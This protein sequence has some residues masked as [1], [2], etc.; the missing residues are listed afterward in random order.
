MFGEVLKLDILETFD[1]TQLT[2]HAQ[3][4]VDFEYYINK[5][6]HLNEKYFNIYLISYYSNCFRLFNAGKNAS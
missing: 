2:C 6:F 1:N 5:M 4:I 3:F